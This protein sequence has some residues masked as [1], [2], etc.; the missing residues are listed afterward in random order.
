MRNTQLSVPNNQ[1]SIQQPVKTYTQEDIDL[2]DEKFKEK[3]EKF[4]KFVEEPAMPLLEQYRKS[5]LK[6]PTFE[7]ETIIYD[8]TIGKWC[9]VKENPTK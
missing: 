6:E 2:I 3:N 4:R 8:P 7:K 9:L 1:Q 5:L